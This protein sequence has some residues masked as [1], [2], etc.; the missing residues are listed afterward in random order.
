MKRYLLDTNTLAAPARTYYA[1][2]RCPQFWDW[3][4]DRNEHGVVFSVH[5]VQQELLNYQDDLKAWAQQRSEDFF[6]EFD[7]QCLAAMAR[8]TKAVADNKY[9]TDANR[10]DFYNQA[11]YYLIAHALAHGFIVV[12]FEQR[13]GADSSKIKIP[14]VCD[15]L[16]L[17]CTDLW[18]LFKEHP[19][20]L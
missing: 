13:V 19:F 1:I 11:D 15:A 20:K 9:Y 2:D 8:V 14:N 17:G 12:T 6:L 16:G 18:G 5:K 10:A 4:I 3:I 7:E